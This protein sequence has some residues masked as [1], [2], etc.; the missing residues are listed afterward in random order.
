MRVLAFLCLAL[1]AAAPQAQAQW[2]IWYASG[3]VP[4]Y[5]YENEH[6]DSLPAFTA[7]QPTVVD[8]IVVRIDSGWTYSEGLAFKISGRSS[9]ENT[10]GT[11]AFGGYEGGGTAVVYSSAIALNAGEAIR[12]FLTG[13]TGSI[14]GRYRYW[15]YYREYP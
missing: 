14:V 3:D 6:V 15:V 10:L 1:C 2:D 13:A 8:R 5:Y 11:L 12:M 9:D 4:A 7:L